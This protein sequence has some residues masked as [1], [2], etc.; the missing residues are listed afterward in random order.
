MIRVGTTPS[1]TILTTAGVLEN[2]AY[3]SGHPIEIHADRAYLVAGGVT[4]YA[5][6]PPAGVSS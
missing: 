3:R 4:W 5:I 1:R 6:L 2:M